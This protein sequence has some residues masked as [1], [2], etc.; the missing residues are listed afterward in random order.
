MQRSSIIRRKNI[1]KDMIEDV[2]SGLGLIELKDRHPMS[3]SGGTI[4]NIKDSR[5]AVFCC[6]T[7]EPLYVCTA[8]NLENLPFIW[9]RL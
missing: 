5:Q 3:L 8:I 7:Y 1:S 6:K 4:E 2:L 9:Y